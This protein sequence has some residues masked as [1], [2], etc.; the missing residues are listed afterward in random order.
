MNANEISCRIPTRKCLD[1]DVRQDQI[2]YGRY[3]HRHSFLIIGSEEEVVE[4]TVVLR[5]TSRLLSACSTAEMYL[6]IF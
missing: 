3:Q 4:G 2:V 1:G 5:S 6:F